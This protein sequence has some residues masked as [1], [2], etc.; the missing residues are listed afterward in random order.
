MVSQLL[1]LPHLRCGFLLA[2]D[3]DRRGAVDEA[4]ASC[5]FVLDHASLRTAPV[6]QRGGAGE[7][8]ESSL[9]MVAGQ[10]DSRLGTS[11]VQASTSV[12]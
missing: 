11:S 8:T 7:Q 12:F 3:P 2:A 9:I 6:Q 1:P 4:W 5:W 10:E